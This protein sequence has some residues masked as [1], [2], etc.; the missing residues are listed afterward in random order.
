METEKR[1]IINFSLVGNGYWGSKILELT[2]LIKKFNLVGVIDSKTEASDKERILSE[3]DLIY[4]ATS[5]SNQQEYLDYCIAKNK[6]IICESPFLA[7]KQQRDTIYKT[8]IENS[9][10]NFFYVNY[11]Y[12]M[13]VLF[14]VPARMAIQNE[15]SFMS[16]KCS[17]P[18]H[19]NDKMKA[20]KMYSCQAL[21][22]I[23]QLMSTKTYKFD[24]FIMHNDD[25]GELFYRN[26]T[27][28][29]SWGYSE[30]PTL[31]ISIKGKDFSIE[32]KFTYDEYD[33]IMPLL[34]MYLTV[35]RNSLDDP[36]MPRS[37]TINALQHAIAAEYFSDL[38][39]AL[40]GRKTES[41]LEN[42]IFSGRFKS[43]APNG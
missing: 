11:P 9:Y 25:Y 36:S 3:S 18:K 30:E 22:I 8:L 28:V 29:F 16:V 1:K 40:N 19:K 15:F 31:E 17:G 43:G 7:S 42:L 5:S 26:S 33:Q 21:N 2:K 39:V 37:I 32:K 23:T 12:I 41:T 13:D 24:K 34:N 4:I 10:Q 38:F 14:S 35:D 20:K 6:D 27:C